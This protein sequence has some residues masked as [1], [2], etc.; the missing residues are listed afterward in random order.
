MRADMVDILAS[1]QPAPDRVIEL[2]DFL[3]ARAALQ[4][5][6]EAPQLTAAASEQSSS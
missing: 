3:K 1:A 4:R 2:D 5:S 6:M